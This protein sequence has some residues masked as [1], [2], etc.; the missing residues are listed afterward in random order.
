MTKFPFPL[1]PRY[2]VQATEQRMGGGQGYVYVCKD[3]Y[4]DRNVAIKVMKAKGDAAALTSELSALCEI[5]SRHVAQVYDLVS[6]KGGTLGLVQEFV[7]GP[8]LEEYAADNEIRKDEYLKVLYQTAC[9]LA[10]IH[11]HG[12]VHRDVKPQNLKFD[13]ERIVKILDFGLVRDLLVKDETTKARGTDGFLGPE[14]YA[15]PPIRFSAAADTYAF[16]VTAWSLGSKGELPDA[17]LEEPPF[18]VTPMQSFSSLGI[19]LPSEIVAVLDSTLS[20][21]PASRP[22]M[23]TVALAIERRL[24]FGRHRALIAQGQTKY[25]LHESGKSVK[26][27]SGADSVSIKYDGLSFTVAEVNGNVY[28]NNIPASQGSELPKSCV[29]TL[30]D[31]SSGPYRTFVA[32]DT[33]HPEV[34]L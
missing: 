27:S 12:K 33:S 17:F 15:T 32:I 8:S 4:L 18:S 20:P 3:T 26:L 21:D 23:K 31:A 30:G 5:K 14:F 13:A 19:A 10:D 1:P 22:R 25:D 34:V 7:P 29:V 9:G 16:G 28:V 11:S 6:S 24:L 2:E